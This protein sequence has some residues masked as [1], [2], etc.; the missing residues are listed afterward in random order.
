MMSYVIISHIF[1][2][3]IYLNDFTVVCLFMTMNY[4][5]ILRSV[6]FEVVCLL[7]P[8]LGIPMSQVLCTKCF[9]YIF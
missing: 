5:T 6:F 7:K 4:N 1:Q 9:I 2:R 3:K 8:I